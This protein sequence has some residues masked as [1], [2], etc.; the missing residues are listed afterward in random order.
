MIDFV[1]VGVV[2]ER[3]VMQLGFEF[4]VGGVVVVA[5]VVD[6]HTGFVDVAAD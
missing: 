2:V 3:L 6:S 1:G 5:A 4:V